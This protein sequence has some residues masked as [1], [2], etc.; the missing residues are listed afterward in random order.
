MINGYPI[1]HSHIKILAGIFYQTCLVYSQL[2]IMLPTFPG[3]LFIAL[4]ALSYNYKS[5]EFELYKTI[6]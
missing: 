4:I 1:L 6:L 5:F 3:Q 2:Q